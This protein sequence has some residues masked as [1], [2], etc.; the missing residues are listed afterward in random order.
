VRATLRVAVN[1]AIRAGH[2]GVNAASRAAA[3]AGRRPRPVVWTAGRIAEW[4]RTAI[5]PVVAVWTPARTDEFLNSARTVMC[6]GALEAE[7]PHPGSALP[8]FRV[9]R[10]GAVF[11]GSDSTSSVIFRAAH[12]FDTMVL[13]DPDGLGAR[14]QDAGFTDVLVERGKAAFRFQGAKL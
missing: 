13:V 9:L 6:R 1:A 2:I 7:R 11:A 5:R 4:K 3:A 14:L 12:L 10:P 8:V